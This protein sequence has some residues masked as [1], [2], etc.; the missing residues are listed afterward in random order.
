MDGSQLDG[1]G[2]FDRLKTSKLEGEAKEAEDFNRREHRGCQRR[3]PKRG[4]FLAV[5]WGVAPYLRRK[6]ST[7]PAVSTSFIL[8]VK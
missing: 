1:R 4:Y 5:A 6:R 8:P 7:R 3:K 2:A